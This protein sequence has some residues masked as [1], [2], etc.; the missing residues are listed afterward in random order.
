MLSYEQSLA[1]K[2][3][4][5]MRNAAQI[6]PAVSRV[7]PGDVSPSAQ[8]IQRP[9]VE[10][11]AGG[12]S[13]SES[14]VA[15]VILP[16]IGSEVVVVSFQVPGGYHGVITGIGNQFVGGGFTEGT[17]DL[18]WRIESDG[19]AIRGYGSILSSLGTTSAPGN[20]SKNPI[21][22][23]EH[24]TVQLILSNVAVVVAGQ[25]LLGLLEGYY[26]PVGVALE[27]EWM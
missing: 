7:A 2:Y 15:S 13:F 18:V 12:F 1:I 5:S 26:Y 20:R 11:P 17:G 3:M 6:G 19:A 25:P 8:V 9:W 23:Y 27:S 21:R 14:N 16:A 24:Q 4:E 10:M 22:V